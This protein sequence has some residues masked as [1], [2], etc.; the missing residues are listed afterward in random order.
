[1]KRISTLL[2]LCLAIL[3]SARPSPADTYDTATLVDITPPTKEAVEVLYDNRVDIVGVHDGVY[4]ALV[5]EDQMQKLSRL[6]FSIEILHAEMQ[7]DRERWVEAAASHGLVTS[8][9]TPSKFNTTNPAAGT[10]MEHL[11][12]QRNAHPDVTR[13]YNLGASQD[14]NY[15]IIAMKVSKNPD[16]VEAEPKIRI[17]ANIHGDEKGGV[18]VACD[19][20]DTILAGYTAVPQDATARKLIDETEMWFIPIGNPYGNANSTRYNSRGID[21]NRNFWG[22]AGSDAPPAWSEKETQVV[23][24]LTETA[25][26]D[27]SKKRFTLSLSF[28]EGEIV[29]NSVW[30]YTTAAPSDEPIFWSSRNG[31]IGLR[32][33]DDPELPDARPERPRASLQGRLHDAGLLVHGRLRLV[34]HE[35]RHERLG[36]RGVVAARHDGRAEHDENASGVADPDLHRSASAGRDQLH[37]EGVPGHSRCRVGSDDGRAAGRNGDRPPRR[38][39]RASPSRTPTKRSTPTLSPETSIACCSPE[40]TRSCAPPPA[41]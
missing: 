32:Q 12:Q 11:L 20:L 27:H 10:L 17:Y 1:V 33:P 39:R 3:A 15:D 19:V 7:A 38:H 8:Y 41:T 25:T 37:D 4:K 9:Y 18:M 28:H 36:V 21:L 13:L 16:T 6:G 29:F 5:T 35:G 14:G 23:R 26:A 34:R 22:P 24:D 40:R 30:N 31:G 2:C